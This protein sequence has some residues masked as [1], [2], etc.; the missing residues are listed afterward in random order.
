LVGAVRTSILPFRNAHSRFETEPLHIEEKINCSRH[1]R[2]LPMTKH[3]NSTAV[4]QA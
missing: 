1:T 2:D 3:V 4:E